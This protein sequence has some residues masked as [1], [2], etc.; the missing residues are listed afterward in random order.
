MKGI[1]ET[2]WMIPQ[3]IPPVIDRRN[4]NIDMNNVGDTP[5]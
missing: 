2:S 5:T 1:S 4:M 3:H